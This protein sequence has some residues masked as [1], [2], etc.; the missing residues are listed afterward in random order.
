VKR[1]RDKINT[2]SP[3]ALMHEQTFTVEEG[4]VLKPDIVTILVE[5]GCVIDV[6]VRYE[7]RDYIKDASVEKIKKYEALKGYSKD[8]YPQLNKVEVMPLVF[9]SRGAVPD[10]TVHNMELLDFTRRKMVHISQSYC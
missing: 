10:S 5:V 3:D 6:T 4:Q 8:L 2:K 1:V 7:D 9:G